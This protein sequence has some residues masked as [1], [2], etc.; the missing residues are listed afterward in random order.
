M[1]SAIQNAK[2][3]DEKV[4]SVQAYINEYYKNTSFDYPKPV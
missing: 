3:E 2:T 1:V 4:Q